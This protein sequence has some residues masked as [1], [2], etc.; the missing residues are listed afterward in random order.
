MSVHEIPEEKERS[1]ISPPGIRYKQQS[2]FPPQAM[3]GC[4]HNEH[5]FPKDTWPGWDLGL[6]L[7]QRTRPDE[8]ERVRA[9]V[10]ETWGIDLL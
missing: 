2:L 1:P 3:A 5:G 9:Y 4:W 10:K 7:L 6:T 8:Y